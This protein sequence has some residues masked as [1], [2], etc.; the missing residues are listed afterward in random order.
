MAHIAT[1]VAFLASYADDDCVVV[2]DAIDVIL[3]AH[4]VT[5][6]RRAHIEAAREGEAFGVGLTNGQIVG[7]ESTR[8]R[9]AV[10]AGIAVAQVAA[11]LTAVGNFVDPAASRTLLAEE[12]IGDVQVIVDAV[13]RHL[14]AHA[15][16]IGIIGRTGIDAITEIRAGGVEHARLDLVATNSVECALLACSAIRRGVTSTGGGAGSIEAGHAGRTNVTAHA[17]IGFV[18]LEIDAQRAALGQTCS[19]RA[20]AHAIGANFA[21]G[22]CFA[23]HT[24]IAGIEFRIDAR[25]TAILGTRATLRGTFAIGTNLTHGANDAASTTIARIDFRIDAG[26]GAFRRTA[27]ALEVA[28]ATGTHFAGSTNRAAR[29][30]IQAVDQYIDARRA[31]FRRSADALQTARSI[32]TNLVLS[33]N[34]PASAA[35][36]HVGFDIDA[37]VAAFR[38]LSDAENVTLPRGADF[39]CGT[40][41]SACTAIRWI[42][43]NIHAL[44]GALRRSTRA[45]HVAFAGCAHL[46]IHAFVAACT[47]IVGIER[48]DRA[49]AIAFGLSRRAFRHATA[50]ATCTAGAHSSAPAHTRRRSGHAATRAAARVA[51][52]TLTVATSTGSDGSRVRAA[53]C[54]GHGAN[55]HCDCSNP[56]FETRALLLRIKIHVYLP[57]WFENQID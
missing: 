42:V 23:A 5:S 12:A 4:V 47:T 54:K 2:G 37:E 16:A 52:A 33:A 43:L 27:A 7:A 41:G 8:C 34:G 36:G 39:S 25:S 11:C 26:I 53:P 35:I 31:A 40:L 17:A 14:C 29:A 30:A 18:I 15:W 55:G 24:A 21:R 1:V 45:L 38:R 32:G 19:A 9:G 22:T 20:S 13:G 44:V 46:A 51:F 56:G 57:P 10:E 3:H 48:R 49:R 50:R 6:L 28:F